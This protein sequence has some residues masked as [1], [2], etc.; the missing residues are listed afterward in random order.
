M[1]FSCLGGLTTDELKE[2]ALASMPFI[3]ADAWKIMSPLRIRVCV[4]FVAA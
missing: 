4:C 2:I 1:T 3:S